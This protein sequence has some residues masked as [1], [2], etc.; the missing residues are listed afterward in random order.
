MKTSSPIELVFGILIA[1]LPVVADF[2]VKSL[3]EGESKN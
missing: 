2:V 1:A 3:Q